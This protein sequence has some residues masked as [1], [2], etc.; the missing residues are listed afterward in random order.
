VVVF[1]GGKVH[2]CTAWMA[3]HSDDLIQTFTL[4]VIIGSSLL[5]E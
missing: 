1:I 5:E 4:D 2:C 3:L